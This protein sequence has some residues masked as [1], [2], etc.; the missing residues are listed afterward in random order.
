MSEN[1]AS[2]VYLAMSFFT[3]LA[4]S[5]MFTT[6]AIYQV[7]A[8]GLSPFE[9][10]MIGMVLEL[11]VLLFEGIT[12]V[13]ADMHGRRK[14]VVIGMFVLGAGFTLEGCAIWLGEMQ[15]WMSAFFWLLIGQL[16]YG[17]GATFV[18]GADAAW[19]AD[20]VGEPKAGPLFL[21]AGR[22]GLAGSL[23]G[24]PLSVLL[25]Q[26]DANVPYL[27]G[28]A[29][30]VLIGAFLLVRMRE[31]GFV[32]PDRPIGR[33]TYWVG[34]KET[35]L[36]GARIVRGRPILFAM[37]LVATL[38]GAASEGYDRLWQAHLMLDI[39]LPENWPTAV[40]I[41]LLAMLSTLLAVPLLRFAENRLDTGNDQAM[42][43]ALMGL[44]LVRIGAIAL[45]AMS[46]GFAWAMAAILV[47][48]AV[49]TLA[50]P[51]SAAW[52]NRHIDSSS[53]ATVL[54][55]MGQSDALGQTAGG[56]FVGW[57]GSRYALRAS[58]LVSAALLTPVIAL[59]RSSVR[60]W[61]REEKE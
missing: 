44:T 17:I 43:R 15:L 30:Y 1:K 26:A 2:R 7:L 13:M 4:N 8:L 20:E 54:S 51:I 16:F 5:I 50:G 36:S 35:W 19:I 23:I 53:R 60:T 14:S 27:A 3:A 32:K 6:Y 22:Y 42:A 47:H 39:G 58:L 61:R 59:Y 9:L 34:V 49:R 10:L 52:M 55:M 12:G 56:P 21:R 45:L 57:I 24:I 40:W 28:G 37:L 38:S 11:T 29:L 48:D 46:P 41:G 18:S 31:T 33:N 25:S